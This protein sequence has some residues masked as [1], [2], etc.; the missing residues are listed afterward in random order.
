MAFGIQQ[1]AAD[2]IKANAVNTQAVVAAIDRLTAMV[3]LVADET[4][5]VVDE[6]F[7]MR[8]VLEKI[9]GH[10]REPEGPP[11]PTHGFSLTSIG[12]E[13]GQEGMPTF[14]LYRVTIPEATGPNSDDV[15]AGRILVAVDGE[16][17]LD[18]DTPKGPTTFEPLKLEQGKVAKVGFVHVDDAGNQ[19]ANP[20]Y[21]PEFTPSDTVPPPDAVDG[22]GL[23]AIGEVTE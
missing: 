18:V 1:A 4:G 9:E 10:L 14:T 23:T 5:L 3:K 2:L 17:Q 15:V 21:L 12:E 8:K 19:S 16:P 11:S 20:L 22:V 7:S 6:L 13:K